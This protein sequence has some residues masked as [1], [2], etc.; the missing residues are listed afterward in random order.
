MVEYQAE[1]EIMERVNNEKNIYRAFVTKSITQLDVG[2]V[3]VPGRIPIIDPAATPVTAGVGGKI[4]GGSYEKSRDLFGP[5]ALIFLDAGSQEG[6][7]LGQSLPIIADE[8]LRN[9]KTP[10][11]NNERVIGTAKIVRLSSGFA[12]AYVTKAMN[13]ILPGD[14]VGTTQAHASAASGPSAPDSD[15]EKEFDS[16]P[17]EPAAPSESGSEEGELEL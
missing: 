11:V 6:L 1:I 12:T 2:A 8:K 3:V 5:S 9:K 4:I 7:Q 10:V 14:F 17:N 15:L 16:M 13:D